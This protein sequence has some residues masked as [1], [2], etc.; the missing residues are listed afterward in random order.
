MRCPKCPPTRLLLPLL[1]GLAASAAAEFEGPACDDA[2]VVESVKQAFNL[3]Q[4]FETRS[5]LELA[6]LVDIR[7]L[8]TIRHDF[9]EWRQVRACA[10]QA[11]VSSGESF[12]GW[13]RVLIPM[14]DEGVRFRVKVCF[15][16][17]D[18]L[19]GGDCLEYNRVPEY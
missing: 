14:I 16:Q 7:E 11:V 8:G 6:S 4:E 17:Y 15:A 12:A 2:E 10:A 1:C 18:P 19:S 5:G 13:H 3:T 9:G